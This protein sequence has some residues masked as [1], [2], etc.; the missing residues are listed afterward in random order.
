[1]NEFVDFKVKTTDQT[2]IRSLWQQGEKLSTTPWNVFIQSSDILTV[3]LQNNIDQGCRKF[4][5]YNNY[6]YDLKRIFYLFKK[7]IKV[8]PFFGRESQSRILNLNI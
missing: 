6:T 8:L 3:Q 1:M 2:S 5:P 7:K 4:T